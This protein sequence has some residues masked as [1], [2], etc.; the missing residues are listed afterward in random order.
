MPKKRAARFASFTEGASPD[1]PHAEAAPPVRHGRTRVLSDKLAFS[2]R[3]SPVAA[4]NLAKLV[5]RTGRPVTHLLDE[6]LTDLFIKHKKTL[7]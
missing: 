2:S 3:I 5:E 7:A 1:Y 6:A 4:D